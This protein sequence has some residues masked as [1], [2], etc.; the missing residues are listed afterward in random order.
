M[1]T[2]RR[3]GRQSGNLYF[4]PLMSD[5]NMEVRQNLELLK[6]APESIFGG[7]IDS[8][9]N[10]AISLAKDRIEWKKNRFSKI[11]SSHLGNKRRI[12]YTLH[13]GES[14]RT[15]SAGSELLCP[16]TCKWS[17]I[18]TLRSAYFVSF[19]FGIQFINGLLI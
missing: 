12:H 11:C 10:A 16:V 15:N 2:P 18:L 9:V 8:D 1:V 4:L 6:T 3:Q 19:Q 14:T 17:S 5:R 7:L 13:C